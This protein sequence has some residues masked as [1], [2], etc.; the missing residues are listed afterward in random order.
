MDRFLF[1]SRNT[2]S[3]VSR[4]GI[5]TDAQKLAYCGETAAVLFHREPLRKIQ[6]NDYPLE[7]RLALQNF[8]LCLQISLGCGGRVLAGRG[9]HVA[10]VEKILVKALDLK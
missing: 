5:P 6:L 7:D 1:A 3:R 4:N 10:Q 9:V 8:D 2:S